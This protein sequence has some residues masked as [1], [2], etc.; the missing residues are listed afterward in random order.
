MKQIIFLCFI[1]IFPLSVL[2]ESITVSGDVYG[3]W[4]VDT[5]LV[6]DEISVPEDSTLAIGP[7]INVLFL[8]YCK[9]IVGTNATLRAIGT[10]SDTIEFETF[11]PDSLWHGIRFNGASDSCK[12]EY[13]HLKNGYSNGDYTDPDSFGGAI[14]CQN[15]ALTLMNCLIDGCTAVSGGAV[16]LDGS[17]ATISY[18]TIISNTSTWAGGGIYLDNNADATLSNNKIIHND[19][20][21]A[22]GIFCDS[23]TPFISHNII[24][25]NSS[26]GL[27]G[28]MWI[29]SCEPTL[30]NN[31]ITHNTGAGLGIS[32]GSFE[33]K[34]CIITDNS[35]LQIY[36]SG[37]PKPQ[38]TYC[39]IEGG[40]SG[41]GNI[42][43]QPHFADPENDDFHLQSTVGRYQNGEWVTDP[44]QSPCID[45]GD[46]ASPFSSEI[47]PNGD[48]INLGIYGNS[49]EASKS[50]PGTP[51]AGIASGEWT[52]SGNPYNVFGDVWI[53]E[54][55]TL[56]LYEGINFIFHTNASFVVHPNATLKALGS[57]EHPITFSAADTIDFW[58]GITL[59]H[60]AEPC[61]MEFCYITDA[62]KEG[63][64]PENSG[65]GILLFNSSPELFGCTIRNCMAEGRGGA[66]ACIDSSGPSLVQTVIDSCYAGSSGGAVY[67]INM[68][69]ISLKNCV[70]CNNETEL[71]CGGLSVSF[72][73][74]EVINCTISDNV[75]AMESGGGIRCIGLSNM[76]I[77]NC[78]V[79]GN[80]G[81]DLQV[82]DGAVAD[83]TYSDIEGG[84]AGLGNFSLPPEF[85]SYPLSLY[86]LS[87]AS[88]C[89]DAG[90][91]NQSYNDPYDPQFPM[92]A[93]FPAQGL[94][95]NDMGAF[96][97][98]N[99][100]GW[101]GIEEPLE[102][103]KSIPNTLILHPVYPNPFNATAM[104]TFDLPVAGEVELTVFDVQGR[105][106]MSVYSGRRKTDP[107]AAGTHS[108][109]FDG[110]GLAS[111]IYFV[112][113]KV[114]RSGATS[115]MSGQ[116]TENSAVRKMVLLK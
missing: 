78:I 15:T 9:F 95:R 106:V 53:P 101:V 92:M 41:N 96:G 109:Q 16:A 46:P 102:G 77:M 11:R 76:T 6:M 4:D 18:N 84:W 93:L 69:D 99:S 37:N 51:V 65:G 58:Q 112:Q 22:G 13:C 19:A 23:S 21:V 87:P 66:I 54:D 27:N 50:S 39:C 103:G 38:V 2:A 24:C 67:A 86:C 45:S 26:N 68:S 10:E 89:V 12:L 116:T 17:D 104:I 25:H 79:W 73:D 63:N 111:G 7:G 5:V 91:P 81:I 40:W 57:E 31:T 115:T 71:Y 83:V 98:M 36:V 64:Y 94:V 75:S 34:N 3:V 8:T 42:D 52:S 20:V 90:N 97:G 56:I 74:P 33:I 55:S 105:D 110:S 48:R 82:S 72:S 100:G 30:I 60:A 32:S 88:P 28:G 1:G 47:M 49:E 43:I 35:Y 108:I 29:Q 62:K 85:Y 113:L 59:D 14:F 114:T 107:Y 80:T 44:V 70:L 61:K